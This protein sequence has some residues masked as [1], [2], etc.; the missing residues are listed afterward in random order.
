MPQD[1]R[2]KF[3]HELL[4]HLLLAR[5][6]L[7]T[8]DVRL[9]DLGPVLLQPHLLVGPLAAEP[10]G[11]GGDLGGPQVDVDA[12]QVVGEDQARHIPPQGVQ[13]RVILLQL[14][15]EVGVA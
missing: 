13:R 11:E 1:L 15:A 5:H 10:E 6:R 7:G 9:G 3:G 4:E 14:R 8:D 2:L 12:V